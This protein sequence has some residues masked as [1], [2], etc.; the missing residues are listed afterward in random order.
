ME[1]GQKIPINLEAGLDVSSSDM[2]VPFNQMTFQHN[3]QKWQG[4]C[5]PN[6]MRFERNGWAAGWNVYDFE[7]NNLDF[8]FDD[9]W[10]GVTKLSSNMYM[11]YAYDLS[12]NEGLMSLKDWRIITKSSILSGDARFVGQNVTGHVGTSVIYTLSWDENTREFSQVT[13]QAVMFH[14]LQLLL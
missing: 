2:L 12:D 5:L 10:I 1:G 14:T 13:V 7:Y 4:K 11:A 8:K 3:W 6:S 9:I